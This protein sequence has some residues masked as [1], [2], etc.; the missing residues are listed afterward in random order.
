MCDIGASPNATYSNF[1]SNYIIQAP[2]DISWVEARVLVFNN[3]DTAAANALLSSITISPYNASGGHLAAFK[4][5]ASNVIM[6][7]ADIA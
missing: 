2:T 7:K 6:L 5:S 4:A 3:S 1:S